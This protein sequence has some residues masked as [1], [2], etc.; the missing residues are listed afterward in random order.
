[1]KGSNLG[2][3][4]GLCWFLRDVDSVRTVGHGGSGN[5]QFA[6]LL[7]VPERQFAVSVLCN[8]GPNGVAFNQAVV[9]WALER[10]LGVLDRDPQPLPYDRAR[11][12]EAAGE[13]E[14]D[15]MTLSIRADEEGA[16]LEV[17]IKPE[18]RAASDKEL[19]TDYPPFAFGLLPGNGDEY[20]VTGGAFTGQRG[21]FSRDET[22]EVVGV[23]LSGRLFRRVPAT[24]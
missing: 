6:G 16:T 19:P 5:G 21:F 14:V 17:R 3:A 15:A 11:I 20:I 7:T 2:D 18:L 9:R 23:D 1:L 8:G 4:F 10:F 22:G 24:A 13:Y 12:T